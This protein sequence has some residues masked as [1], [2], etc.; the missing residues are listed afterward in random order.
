MYGL[1]EALWHAA[2]FAYYEGNPAEVERLASKLI[3]LSTRHHFA[4]WLP[5][6]E[7]L[8][9]WAR[10]T[11]GDAAQGISWIGVLEGS[12]PG[13]AECCAL[14]CSTLMNWS[15]KRRY[16]TIWGGAGDDEIVNLHNIW[17]EILHDIFRITQTNPI[18]SGEHLTW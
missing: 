2:G 15:V 12:R 16:E 3:E 6:G 7:V 8:R 10:S 1:A 11:F 14:P 13:G 5:H 17:R 18:T 9:G 4:H